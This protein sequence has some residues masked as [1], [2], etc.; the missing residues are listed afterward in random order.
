[1]PKN[2]YGHSDKRFLDIPLKIDEKNDVQPTYASLNWR[3]SQY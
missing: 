1:M 3:N 2:V